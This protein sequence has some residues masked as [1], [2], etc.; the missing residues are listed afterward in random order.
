M[1][2]HIKDRTQTEGVLRTMGGG[3]YLVLSGNKWQEVGENLMAGDVFLFT[4]QQT[5][6]RL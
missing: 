3:E 2:V 1:V 6:L 4:L 5:L